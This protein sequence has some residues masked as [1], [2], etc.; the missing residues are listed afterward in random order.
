MKIIYDSQVFDLQKFGGISRYFV[1]LAN[2]LNKLNEDATFPIKY[3]SNHYLQKAKKLKPF[4]NINK[5]YPGKFRIT[6]KLNR[7]YLKNHLNN[8]DLF[9]PTYFDPYFLELIGE[10]PF[11]FTIYD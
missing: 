8:F 1:Q 3:S 6:S 7:K 2:G 4:L 11:V 5:D 10:R 9:H